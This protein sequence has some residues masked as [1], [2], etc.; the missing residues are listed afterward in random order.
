LYRG[1]SGCSIL[2]RFLLKAWS[3]K[4]P[5]LPQNA[6]GDRALQNHRS[7]LDGETVFKGMHLG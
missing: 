7:I 4:I 5:A 1:N 2:P 6:A 3:Q